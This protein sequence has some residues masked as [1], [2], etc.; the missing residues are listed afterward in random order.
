VGEEKGERKR[1]GGKG[2]GKSGG[3]KGGRGG[4]KEGEVVIGPGYLLVE[5]GPCSSKLLSPSC[6]VSAGH[7]C[8]F[9]SL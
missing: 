5:G 4:G 9:N 7:L 2:G 6:S 3:G 8:G 1:G